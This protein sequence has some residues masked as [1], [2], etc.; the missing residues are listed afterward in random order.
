MVSM[1]HYRALTTDVEFEVACGLDIVFQMNWTAAWPPFRGKTRFPS[2]ILYVKVVTVSSLIL[3]GELVKRDEASST[4]VTPSFRCSIFILRS[5]T[6]DPGTPENLRQTILVHPA[7]PAIVKLDQPTR[8]E[9]E[10]KMG[11]VPGTMIYVLYRLSYF[12][13]YNGL[14]VF[15][16]SSAASPPLDGPPLFPKFNCADN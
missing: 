1:I 16:E 5:T 12:S 2:L 11:N 14:S 13:Q 8:E 3:I 15:H 4:L 10:Q 7:E 6:Q 9:T